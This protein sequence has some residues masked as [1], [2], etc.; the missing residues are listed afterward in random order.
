MVV[1]APSPQDGV[2]ANIIRPGKRPLDSRMPVLLRTTI[3]RFVQP[4]ACTDSMKSGRD[5]R[6]TSR[7][8]T[9]TRSAKETTSSGEKLHTVSKLRSNN[10]QRLRDGSFD[11]LI[12]GGGI[13]GAVSA[14]ALAAKGV[15]VAL[16][17]RGDF[18]GSTSQS[19]S[20][21]AWG[22]IKYMESY[23]FGLVRGLCTARN[24]LIRHF[25]STVKEIRF[26]TTINATFRHGYARCQCHAS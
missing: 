4:Q 19:S 18:A 26:L 7:P 17:D 12:V 10:I 21:L 6:A 5:G 25:P 2:E 11:V 22:G 8:Q 9:T 16:V 14:A 23:E 24:R 20:N 13:N 15:R 1:S 3:H